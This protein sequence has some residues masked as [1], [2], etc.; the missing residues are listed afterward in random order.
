MTGPAKVRIVIAGPRELPEV[1]ALMGRA[2]DPRFGEAWSGSQL[3]GALT[4]PDTWVQVAGDADGISGFT[5][6]RRILDEAELM[7]VAVAPERRAM[8]LG[9]QLLESA[10]AQAH[11][12]GARSMFL[13][14]RDG[15]TAARALYQASGFAEIGRRRDYYGGP[16]NQRYDAITLRRRLAD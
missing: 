10:A 14:V 3:I 6:V 13:E 2:F 5:L 16:E 12:R 4:I 1:V 9:R 7:L 15:N 11:V 8:G